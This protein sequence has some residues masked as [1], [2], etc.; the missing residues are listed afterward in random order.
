MYGGVRAGGSPYFYTWYRWGYGWPFERKYQPLTPSE[1]RLADALLADYV[2]GN[3][4]P[5]CAAAPQAA[6]SGAA[7]STPAR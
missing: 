2:A 7:R 1:R 3:P 5:V 4:A 6:R